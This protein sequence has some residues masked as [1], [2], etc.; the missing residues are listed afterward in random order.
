MH[1]KIM[2]SVFVI[3]I[4]LPCNTLCTDYSQEDK[5]F[6]EENLSKLREYGPGFNGKQKELWSK[7]ITIAARHE[8]YDIIKVMFNLRDNTDAATANQYALDMFELYKGNPNFFVKSLNRYYKGDIKKFLPTWINEIGD[9]TYEQVIH[10]TDQISDKELTRK[11]IEAAK[12]V[13]L[14]MQERI[15]RPNNLLNPDVR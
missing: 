15:E 6:K 3:L 8:D 1:I 10:Y 7:F 2:L 9:I 13:K 14:E 11:F 5:N 12:N 4:V